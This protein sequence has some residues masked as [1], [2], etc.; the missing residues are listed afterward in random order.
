[1]PKQT[2]H[3][4][5]YGCQM[6]HSDSERINSW[7]QKYNLKPTTDKDSAHLIIF[8]AC[9]VRQSAIDR[10]WGQIN[11]LKH[12]NPHGR[13]IL[14]GCILPDDK[15]KFVQHVDL[16]LNI[17]DLP[18]WPKIIQQQFKEIN[19]QDFKQSGSTANYFKIQP[20]H[21]SSY[22]AYVPIMT[23]CNNFCSYCAVP[24]TRGREQSR[25]ADDIIKE[26]RQ[27]IKKGYKE[28]ILLGQNVNSYRGL[29][30][31]AF[32]KRYAS[33]IKTPSQIIN[34][35]VLLKIIDSLAGDYWLNFVSSH[36][37]DLSPQLI[38]S[39][40]KL[41]HLTPY[42]HLALQSG[43]DKILQAMNRHYTAKNYLQL[44]NKIRRAQP[45]I[46]LTTD[47]IVGYPGET[48]KDFQATAKLM[49]Q[50]KFDM[51]YIAQYSPR[52]NTAAARLDDN[53][54]KAEK[55]HREKILTDILAQNAF[56]HNQQLV[57]QTLEVLIEKFNPAQ[58]SFF[59]HTNQFKHVK[60]KLKQPFTDYKKFIGQFVTV[61][62]SRATPW[63]LE[64]KK[65]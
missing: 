12:H 57:N 14:T 35:P 4:I 47:I 11:N 3:L 45:T 2:Y 62:I 33:Y 17:T 23:G 25:P 8:N 24:Y 6:N 61:K 39:Y 53:V 41:K 48:K 58:N 1:M 16:I 32:K 31:L 46:A 19:L 55:K 64:G 10:I 18:Q 34:F 9:S 20:H 44:I 40:K 30:S 51:A 50:I 15:K 22:Q 59:G 42:L 5:T 52:P 7:L 56:S 29:A 60:I 27:L 63:A 26:I 54:P 65:I 36:P 38:Q 13:I 43:S 49:R 21:P 37:K 28:I